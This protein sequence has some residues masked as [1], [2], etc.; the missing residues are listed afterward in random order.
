MNRFARS[1]SH[2]W[3]CELPRR[4]LSNLPLPT[5]THAHPIA[6]LGPKPMNSCAEA[7]VPSPAETTA[8][9]TSTTPSTTEPAKNPLFLWGSTSPAIAVRATQALEGA[10][11]GSESASV[12]PGV[13]MGRWKDLCH[14]LENRFRQAKAVELNCKPCPAIRFRIQIPTFRWFATSRP[15]IASYV[16]KDARDNDRVS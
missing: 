9:V 3:H 7:C 14:L 5:P 1:C 8:I 2:Q 16:S 11:A 6:A 10:L 15:R 12:S 13:G 4:W